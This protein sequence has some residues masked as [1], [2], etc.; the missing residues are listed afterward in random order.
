[1]KKKASLWISG[2]TTVAMLAVAVG[3]FAAWDTL[4]GKAEGFTVSTGSPT[5]LTVTKDASF[6]TPTEALIPKNSEDGKYDVLNTTD[7]ATEIAVGKFTAKLEN[8]PADTKITITK[9]ILEGGS[10][11]TAQN[12]YVVNIYEGDNATPLTLNEISGLDSTGK[13]Y[14]VKVAFAKDSSEVVGSDYTTAKDLTVN[15]ELV[16]SKSVS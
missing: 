5:A 9:N 11:V 8:A 6:T 15:L 14:T 1:M 10:D 13:T 3:S 4:T 16:A 12:K 7:A 2:I